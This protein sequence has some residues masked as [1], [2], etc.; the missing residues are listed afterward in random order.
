LTFAE[1]I[2]PLEAAE[3]IEERSLGDERVKELLLT[4]EWR[5]PLDV[6]VDDI[7]RGAGGDGP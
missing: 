1:F 5:R 6:V 3:I 7:S 4:V 2:T